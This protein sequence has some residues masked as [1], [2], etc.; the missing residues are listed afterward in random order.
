MSPPPRPALPPSPLTRRWRPSRQTFC[1]EVLVQ[2]R[3]VNAVP[4]ARNLPPASL[5]FRC[6]EEF[7]IPHQ[8]NRDGHAIHEADRQTLVSETRGQTAR[9]PPDESAGN[10][11]VNA[12]SFVAI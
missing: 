9:F 8:R 4:T 7:W 11:G 5:R 10:G 12:R 1:A 3:P 6:F 2:V